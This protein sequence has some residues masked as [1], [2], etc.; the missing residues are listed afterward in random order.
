MTSVRVRLTLWYFAVLGVSLLIFGV[1]VFVL[2]RQSVNAVGHS[3]RASTGNAF[4]YTRSVE[5]RGASRTRSKR[6]AKGAS[7]ASRY[8]PSTERIHVATSGGSAGAGADGDGG[9]AAWAFS[10]RS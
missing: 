3:L 8:S 4:T 9:V 10:Q 2:V 7:G 1:T 5:G 6:F